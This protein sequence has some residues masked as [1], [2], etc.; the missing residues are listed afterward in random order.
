MS[1]LALSLWEAV[2]PPSIRVP[3]DTATFVSYILPT[4]LGYFVVA[5]LAVTPQTHVLRLA[6]WSVITLLSFRA[7]V[8]VDMSLGEPDQ[9]FRNAVLVTSMAFIVVRTFNWTLTKEPL[10]RQLR[11]AKQSESTLMDALDLASTLRGHGWDWSHGVYIPRETRPTDRRRFTLCAILSATFHLLLF[12]VLH[13]AMRSFSPVGLGDISGGSIFDEALLLH[14]RYLRASVISIFY[15]FALYALV[16]TCYD[17]CT[18][19]SV[20]VF[21]QDPVQWPPAFDAPWRATSLNDFWGRR[22]HQ[23]FRMF[24]VQASHPLSFFLGKAGLVIGAF[25]SSAVLHHMALVSLD[26]RSELW[27]NLVGFGMM[28][29]GILA[30]RAFKRLTGNK[31]G[32]MVGWIWTMTWLVLWGNVMIDAHTRAGVFGYFNFIGRVVPGRAAVERLVAGFDD[33]LHA[34]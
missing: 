2:Y 21:G 26:D 27:R 3:I 18:M 14:V 1:L 32:G 23:F 6:F 34:M 11:P 25:L 15:V 9:R 16:Q 31:V 22:W 4:V 19:T 28:A 24:L 33:W 10:E 5:V 7:A 8:S 29:P 13:T 12:G 30:E 17:L 20:L